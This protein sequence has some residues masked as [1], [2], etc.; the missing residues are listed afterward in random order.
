META[1]DIEIVLPEELGQEVVDS[2][3]VRGPVQADEEHV[4]VVDE[5]FVES[6]SENKEIN[7]LSLGYFDCFMDCY[8]DCMY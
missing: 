6:V 5:K 4:C 3:R 1:T 8:F 2:K 7:V